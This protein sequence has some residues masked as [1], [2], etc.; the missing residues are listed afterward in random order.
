M[1]DVTIVD[2]G[3]T[4]D[5]KPIPFAPGPGTPRPDY[6]MLAGIVQPK[7]AGNYF[8][9]FYGPAKTVAKNEAA[10]KKMLEGLEAK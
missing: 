7:N 1:Q 6:R 4:Y 10:F 2:I 9:K 8:I 5:D 3:G